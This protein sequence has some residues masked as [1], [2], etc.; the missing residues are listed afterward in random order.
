MTKTTLFLLILT[1]ILSFASASRLEKQ[2]QQQ[3][4]KIVK[5]LREVLFDFNPP[6][7]RVKLLFADERGDSL[8]GT[9]RE[10]VFQF[11]KVWAPTSTNPYETVVPIYKVSLSNQSTLNACDTVKIDSLPFS[12]E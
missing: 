11:S 5:S 1:P 3:A 2:C 9:G 6:E 10:Y 8:D 4:E 7:V 12:R